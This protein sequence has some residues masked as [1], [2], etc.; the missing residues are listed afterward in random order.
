MDSYLAGGEAP[1]VQGHAPGICICN[2]H[3][4]GIVLNCQ[5]ANCRCHNRI[6][7]ECFGMT[8]KD[9]QEALSTTWLVFFILGLI[10]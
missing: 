6:H 8:D 1:V 2:K 4:D 9:I 5:G 3:V 10:S 7:P